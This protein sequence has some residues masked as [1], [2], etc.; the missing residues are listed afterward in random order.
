MY[1][2]VKQ[3]AEKWGFLTDRFSDEDAQHFCGGIRNDN[4]EQIPC[5]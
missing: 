3:A 2:T 4:Q 1:I 5:L